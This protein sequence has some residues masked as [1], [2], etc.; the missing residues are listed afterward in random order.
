M[1]GIISFEKFNGVVTALMHSSACA[2]K[3][4]IDLAGYSD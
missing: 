3:S 4:H 2:R 1:N